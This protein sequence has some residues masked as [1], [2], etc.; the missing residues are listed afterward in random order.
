MAGRA[1]QRRHQRLTL[2]RV[3]GR[4]LLGDV[5]AHRRNGPGRPGRHGGGIHVSRSPVQDKVG[6][7]LDLVV[8]QRAAEL[9]A[10]GGHALRILLE[11]HR[12]PRPPARDGGVDVVP[13][14]AAPANFLQPRAVGQQVGRVK[15]GRQRAALAVQA[16][17]RL[18]VV[19]K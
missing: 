13:Y 11:L 2:G 19:F 1:A 10:P 14:S 7:R 4:Q 15:G 8:A 17:A 3:A 5:G 12:W 16:V 6:D 18:T 9:L